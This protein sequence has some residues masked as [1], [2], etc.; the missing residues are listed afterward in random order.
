VSVESVLHLDP[1]VILA[2]GMGEVRPEWLDEWLQWKNL[3]AVK[4]QQL[5]FI[6]PDLLQRHT[7]RILQGAEILC[8]QLE[9]ARK[10]SK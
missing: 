7:V 2:S 9:Q 10:K 6:H 4:N 8:G 1:Q 3:I 5:F